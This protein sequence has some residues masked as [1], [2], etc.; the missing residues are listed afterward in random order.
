MTFL[1]WGILSTGGITH[2]MVNA[3]QTLPDAQVVAVGSRT[4]A[5][6]DRFGDQYNI[7]HRHA[8]Y[9]AL[10]HD[11]DVD[12]IYI[13]TPHVFHAENM[14]LC[15]NA[16]KHVLCEKPFT[17]NAREA[18]E[19]IA[20]AREKN[21]LLVE[22][23]WVRWQPEFVQLRRWIADGAIG[24]VRLLRANLC[25][26]LNPDPQGRI[27]NPAL[28]GGA[29]LDVGVYPV[30][31]AS[32]ILGAPSQIHS[33]VR[34]ADSTGVDE[35]SVMTF[36][37]ANGAM[38]EL[39]CAVN[40]TAPPEFAVMGTHGYIQIRDHWDARKLILARN[41][42]SP[43]IQETQFSVTDYRFQA[44]EVH[45]LLRA[46]KTESAIMPLDETLSVMRT[47]DALRA[48]WGLRYPME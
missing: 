26:R 2:T 21:L 34:L 45:D 40:F 41:E 1:R 13:A 11:P 18:A 12:V 43:V 9:E 48:S 31:F 19:C 30:S 8:S 20:L 6:A 16:G 38:A 46:G 4:Q 17:I 14:K 35:S 29:L 10:A 25:F 39:A 3:L 27:Y 7:P 36:E 5:A 22:A 23:M 24:D 37:Y 44:M 15:L 47:L 33:V 42:E 28:G 32:M